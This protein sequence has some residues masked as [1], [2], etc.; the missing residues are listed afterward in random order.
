M[1]TI[2]GFIFQTVICW[3]IYGNGSIIERHER[4]LIFLGPRGEAYYGILLA[5]TTISIG[6]SVAW[7]F[8]ALP[9]M[10]AFAIIFAVIATSMWLYRQLPLLFTGTAIGLYVWAICLLAMNFIAWV[11]LRT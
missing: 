5:I 4:P 2:F 10:N 7:E 6:S 8:V 11:A 1:R 3:S 9:W